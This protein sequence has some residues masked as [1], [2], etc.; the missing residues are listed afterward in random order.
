M[1]WLRVSFVIVDR[2]F[3]RTYLSWLNTPL[4]SG[5]ASLQTVLK[6]YQAFK[7]TPQS[8]KNVCE[9]ANKHSKHSRK[10]N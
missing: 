9:S 10:R 1:S 3:L 5:T 6:Y 2:S 4:N 8:S 7:K